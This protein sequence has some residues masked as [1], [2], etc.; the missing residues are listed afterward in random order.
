MELIYEKGRVRLYYMPTEKFKTE[1]ISVSFCAPLRREKAYQNALIPMVLNRGTRQYP[2]TGAITKHLMGLYGAG[3]GVDVDK[4]G[5]IQLLQ[6]QTDYAAPEYAGN[7]PAI[8]EK[9]SRFLVEVMTHPAISNDGG[10]IE[11]YFLQEKNNTDQF[12]RS[13]INDKQSYAM[14][15]CVEAM[16]KDEPFGVSEIGSLGEG[17]HLTAHSLYEVYQNDFLQTMPVRIFCCARQEPRTLLHMLEENGILTS[18]DIPKPLDVGYL[19]KEQGTLQEVVESA[20]VQQGKLNLGFRT[21]VAPDS[22]DF[23]AL[24][25][26][27][28]IFGGGPQSKLFMN[29]REKHSL[30]YYASSR[31]E[32]HKGLMF[33]SCGID[34]S[35]K[36]QTQAL[37]LAQLEDIRAGKI[38]DV[39]LRAAKAMLVHALRS[40]GDTQ[41]SLMDYYIGQ[42]FLP[43]VTEI[44]TYIR[45]VQNVDKEAVMRV[46]QR[47]QADTVYFLTGKEG[48]PRG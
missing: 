46:A 26:M 40:C 30:A 22:S 37:V 13:E 24:Y 4:K 29:V 21:N 44:D 5:E 48:C 36:E 18:G 17:D 33:V 23:Y 31:L 2:S 43:N 25:V 1:A 41:F 11:S 15:R 39:E 38:T 6:F 19:E 8:E 10:F 12:I 9:I 16:C 28:A 14:R 42:S 27:N 35:K 7:C 20:D 3:F 32:R 45:N 47:V 34:C